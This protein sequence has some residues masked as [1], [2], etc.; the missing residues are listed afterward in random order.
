MAVPRSKQR[1]LK[2]LN[3]QLKRF[4]GSNEKLA[5]RVRVKIRMVES[6]KG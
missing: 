5:D 3:D 2:R 6:Q 1:N 4:E